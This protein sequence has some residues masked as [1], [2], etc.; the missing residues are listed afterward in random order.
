LAEDAKTLKLITSTPQ[1]VGLN[2][3]LLSLHYPQADSGWK[4]EPEKLKK[5]KPSE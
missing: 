2:R 1:T 5:D 4:T 3:Q